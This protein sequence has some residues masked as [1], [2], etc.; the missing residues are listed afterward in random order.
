MIFIPTKTGKI[1]DN[2]FTIKAMIVNMFIIKYGDRVICI[3][4]G[5]G[6]SIIKMGLK[7]LNIDPETVS[8]IFLTHSDYDHAGC[9]DLFKNASV[10]LSRNEEQMI[11]GKKSRAFGIRYNNPIKREYSLLDNDEVVEIDD[12]SVRG[13]ETPGHTPGSMSYLINDEY[14]FVGDSMA[15]IGNRVHSFPFFINMDTPTQK[16]SIKKLSGLKDVKLVCTAHSGYTKDFSNAVKAWRD[17]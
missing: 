8:H 9:I 2:I 14:L 12:I 16:E 15:L 1:T 5:L 17:L 4:T 7:K 13:I 11:T 10:F 6:S 3:D